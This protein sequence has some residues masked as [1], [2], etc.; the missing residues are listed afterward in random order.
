MTAAPG[1]NATAPGSL[2]PVRTFLS[3]LLTS[4]AMVATVVALPA[5]WVSQRVVDEDG[6]VAVVAPLAHDEQ[7]Q[8]Y[9]ADE[10]TTQVASRV[11]YPG[12]S[13]VVAP[14][15]KAYTQGES[16]PTDFTD[17]VRQ[18]HSWLFDPAPAGSAG[19]A[20]QLDI[21]AMVDRALSDA[22]LPFSVPAGAAIDVPVSEGG[23]EAGRYHLIGTQI[24]TIG[25]VAVVVAVIAALLA[26][27]CA[28]RR[29]TVLIWLG[30]GGLLAALG[31]WLMAL[32]ATSIVDRVSSVGADGGGIIVRVATNALADDLTRWSTMAAIAGVVVAVVGVIV[33]VA[34]RGP[35]RM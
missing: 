17:L 1:G 32:N 33:R 8:A 19:Q 18:E 6:F 16:F 25:Y 30:I 21:T 27:V 9:I 4:I 3:A 23:L 12:A 10:I 5:M 20:M 26:L 2:V 24:T 11:G 13:A 29:G 7:V 34:F 35:V 14:V 15:A 28:R 31:C 22:H